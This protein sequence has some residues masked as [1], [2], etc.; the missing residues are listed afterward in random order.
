MRQ[1]S[2]NL[3]A[4][5][6]ASGAVIGLMFAIGIYKIP[7][8]DVPW[9]LATGRWAIEHGHFPVTN[10]FSWTWPDHPLHQQYPLFQIPLAL[11]VGSLGWGSVTIAGAALWTAV[12]LS[13][14][15]WAGPW[16]TLAEQPMLWLLVVLG[17]QRH[18]TA[19]PEVL[20]LL[21]LGLLLC[22][23]ES[24][25]QRHKGFPWLSVA[26]VGLSQWMMV[27]GHQLWPLGIAVQVSFLIHLACVRLL[28]GYTLGELRVDETDR[29]LPFAP[30]LAALALSLLLAMISPLGAGVYLAPLAVLDTLREQGHT[31]STGA[32]AVELMP[33]WSDPLSTLLLAF[34]LVTLLF[35]LFRARRSIAPF[36]LA[37]AL[38]GALLVGAAVRGMPFAALS[39]GAVA[40][41]CR[42][43]SGPLFPPESP[44]HAATAACALLLSLLMLRVVSSTEPAYFRVQRG[45]GRTVGEWGDGVSAFLTASPPPGEMLNLGWVVGNPMIGSVY[46]AKRVFV[47]PRWEAYPKPFLLS[48]IASMRDARELDA[49]IAEHEPGFIVAEMRLLEVQQRAG[50]LWSTGRW[51]LVYADTEHIVLVRDDLASA[52][53]LSE[54]PP[55]PAEQLRERFEE[56]L[57]PDYPILRAQQQIRAA[58]LL[59]ILGLGEDARAL[60]E[61]ARASSSDPIVGD[62]LATLAELLGP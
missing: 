43:R 31:T 38:M 24:L 11:L 16:R 9:H 57:L 60:A 41:R 58:R 14:A 53:W 55:I 54:H 42:R 26:L 47:D 61:A 1:P 21:G 8:V 59:A 12:T 7:P 10:T 50:E 25:R 44:L 28:A 30:P 45:F 48:A 62:E 36:D 33:V 51:P 2:G 32:Q 39:F 18:H 23:I 5:W 13:W 35:W 49:L 22:S 20:T 27:N 52:P 40:A 6:L 19:R 29:D 17:V 15:R 56:G 4:G 37:V 34:S 3:S 46:P